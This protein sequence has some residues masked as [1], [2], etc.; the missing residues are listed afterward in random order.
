VPARVL[1]A[2]AVAGVVA[3][4]A[5]V[6]GSPAWAA[7]GSG[8]YSSTTGG[9]SASGGQITVQAGVS[10]WSPPSGSTWA[11]RASS[12]PPPGKPNPNQP[13]G[14]RYQLAGPQSS[15][16]LGPGG[17]T[18][19][20]WVFPI[21]AG[22]GVLNPMPPFWVAQP[23]AQAAAVQVNP[24]VVA[25]QAVS[26]LGLPSPRIGMAP[27]TGDP[28]LV[29]VATWMWV[30]QGAWGSL[31]ATATAG[32]VTV[33]AMAAPVKVTWD[34][35]DGHTVTCNGPGTPYSAAAPN[36]TTNC[37]YTWGQAGT[38]QVTATVYWSVSWAAV[39]APGGGNLGVQAGPATQVSVTVTE[40]QAINTPS[41][42]GN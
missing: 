8:G 15:Q 27:P 1:T 25:Q 24:A 16:L 5:L 7:D 35:G 29:G 42:G 4:L 14:C 12:A 20:Q 36:A 21:C 33:T 18:P 28:Q 31:S 37:S 11:T 13:Y 2:A 3:G 22:P 17:P 6:G 39:G 23:Q 9:A 41:G 38:Y 34:M 40:S 26:K 19:G 30:N 32:P 10:S